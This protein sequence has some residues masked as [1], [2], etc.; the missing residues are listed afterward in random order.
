M[1]F[2][3]QSSPKVR[4]KHNVALS[5]SIALQPAVSLILVFMVRGYQPSLSVRVVRRTRVSLALPR[6]RHDPIARSAASIFQPAW[7]PGGVVARH[8]QASVRHAHAVEL[9]YLKRGRSPVIGTLV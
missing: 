8:A 4:K 3:G 1:E 7:T 2:F 9:R 5:G 6:H